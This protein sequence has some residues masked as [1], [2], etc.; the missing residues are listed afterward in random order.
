MQQVQNY[1]QLK[2][3]IF[4]YEGKK[5]KVEIKNKT[6]FKSIIYTNLNHVMPW[7]ILQIHES[8]SF[9]STVVEFSEGIFS[10]SF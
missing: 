4:R 7:K 10:F 8:R 6:R 9:I 2:R 3:M 1:A 5:K